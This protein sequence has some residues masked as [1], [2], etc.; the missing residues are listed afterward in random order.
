MKILTLATQVSDLLV[1][2]RR[3]SPLVVYESPTEL[4]VSAW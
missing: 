1:D 2:V 4:G 3:H